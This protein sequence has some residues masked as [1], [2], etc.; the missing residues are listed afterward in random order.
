MSKLLVGLMVFGLSCL[1]A[2]EVYA[3]FT[4]EAGKSANL[5]FTASGVVNKIN[6]EIGSSVKKGQK[7]VVLENNERRTLL[8]IAKKN[9]NTAEVKA[10]Y[11]QKEYQRQSQVKSLVEASTINQF[12]QNR[13]VSNA[14]ITQLEASLQTAQIAAEYAQDEYE[15]QLKVRHLLDASTFDQFTKNRD[16]ARAKVLQLQANIQTAQVTENYA[17]TEYERQLESRQFLD[18]SAFERFA[19]NRDVA[20]ASVSQLKAN[21]KHQEILLHKTALYAP[22]NGVIFEKLVE[23]GDVVS[24]QMLR[25]VLKIQ[26][27]HQRKLILE[28]DQKYWKSVKVGDK[29]SYKVD[30]S[31]KLYKGVISKIY[32][33]IDVDKRKI[34]AEVKAK[35]F[36]VGLFGDGTIITADKK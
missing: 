29:F 25:T 19:Q 12:E 18:T 34:K 28:F 4:V 6:I 13:D 2:K 32:P 1:G 8:E 3:T 36:I 5:A 10:S 14:N 23:V 16:I 21:V 17:Q 35:D 33:T 22:F 30:G 24:G 20:Q 7:L 15:R 11:A 26:S 31:D 9:L 27:L